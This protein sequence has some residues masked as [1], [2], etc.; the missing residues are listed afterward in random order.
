MHIHSDRKSS[1]LW[2][3]FSNSNILQ[4]LQWKICDDRSLATYLREMQDVEQTRKKHHRIKYVEKKLKK[5][6][7]TFVT[8]QMTD[9]TIMEFT[10]KVMLEEEIIVENLRRKIPVPCLI[11][12]FIARLVPLAMAQ[13]E[14]GSLMALIWPCISIAGNYTF[15]PLHEEILFHPRSHH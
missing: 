13:Q 11:N 2:M 7:T 4:S 10:D 5:T 14:T 1:R 15:H 6:L 9:G 8:K 12:C 3:A